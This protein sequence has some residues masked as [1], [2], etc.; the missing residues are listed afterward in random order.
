M[1]TEYN[2]A[3]DIPYTSKHEMENQ[4]FSNSVKPSKSVI[5]PIECSKY[6]N[7]M[8]IQYTRAGGVPPNADIRMYDLGIFTIATQGMQDT[9]GTIGELW[10]SYEIEF[11]KPKQSGFE[12]VVTNSYF[13]DGHAISNAS[14]NMFAGVGD[15]IVD[16]TSATVGWRKNGPANLIIGNFNSSGKY[17]FD[18]NYVRAGDCFHFSITMRSFTVFVP[19]VGNNPRFLPTGSAANPNMAFCR[20]RLVSVAPYSNQFYVCPT[21]STAGIVSEFQVEFIIEILTHKNSEN[22][23]F[24][25][26]LT[27]NPTTGDTCRLDIKINKISN[28]WASE[29]PFVQ[30]I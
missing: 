11:F 25:M 2:S 6:Q 17:Q 3:D 26:D 24:T 22:P 12:N 15:Y 13:R 21:L 14:T 23:G 7:P 18:G 10:V 27:A 19:G 4:E 9:A 20:L 29:Y 1:A 5:H 16:G 30:V 28:Q 8:N